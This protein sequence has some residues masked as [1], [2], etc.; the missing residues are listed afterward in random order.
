[1]IYYDYEEV[2]LKVDKL[3]CSGKFI[4]A[5]RMLEEVLEEEPGYGPA[6][7][8]LGW[9]YWSRLDDYEKAERHFKLALKFA[10]QYPLTYYS[11]IQLLNEVNDNRMLTKVG[12]DALKVRGMNRFF[13]H[14]ELG[15]SFEM[16]AKL[17]EAL[18]EYE[19]AQNCVAGSGDTDH[20]KANI[21]RVKEK[22]FLT[23]MKNSFHSE[24]Q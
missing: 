15:K 6:H 2:L 3:F 23:S 5:K 13:V 1:M 14:N 24:A 17:A 8:K 22:M 18:Q 19:A 7:Y 10:P 12:T 20:V 21:L 9:L 11:F 4:L 16:N